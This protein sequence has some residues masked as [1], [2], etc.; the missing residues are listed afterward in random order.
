M[1]SERRRHVRFS[2]T[3]LVQYTAGRQ[4]GRVVTGDLSLAGLYLVDLPPL[5]VGRRVA[6]KL[7]LPHNPP[8]ALRT[9]VRRV[10]DNGA[11]VEIV[12]ASDEARNLIRQ[13]IDMRLA[14][15][16]GARAQAPDAS[17]RDIAAYCTHRC[18][19]GDARRADEVYRLAL[20]RRPWELALYEGYAALLL[21]RARTDPELDPVLHELID[22]GLS[23]GE[24]QRLVA[25]A[26]RLRSVQL[27]RPPARR[28]VPERPAVEVGMTATEL[29]A[30]TR[31]EA[32]RAEPAR[33]PLAA[34]MTTLALVGSMALAKLASLPLPTTEIRW[35][36]EPRASFAAAG[37]VEAPPPVRE[38]AV[39]LPQPAPE[40]APPPPAQKE[41]P[42]RPVLRPAKKKRSATAEPPAGEAVFSLFATPS[43]SSD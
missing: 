4:T 42:R 34:G 25:I 8:V 40:L 39:P 26:R 3:C 30:P 43:P 10:G 5:Q 33:G 15:D 21:E 24:S 41:E 28:G 23:H 1:D 9:I 11:G 31:P 12:G 32:P 6:C 20:R 19:V 36:T 16:L 29:I 22:T 2:T 14:R 37:V 7:V 17:P 38:V 18:E 27:E 35:L 13:F